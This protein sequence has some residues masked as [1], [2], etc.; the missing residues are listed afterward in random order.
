M[1]L[2]HRPRALGASTVMKIAGLDPNQGVEELLGAFL[3]LLNGLL[4]R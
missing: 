1:D 2:E 4:E 3:V